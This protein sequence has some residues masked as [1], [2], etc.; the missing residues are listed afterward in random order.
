MCGD[1]MVET[2]ED[3]GAI[4]T[5]QMFSTTVFDG[6][7]VNG[8]NIVAN[9]YPEQ[10]KRILLMAHWDTRPFADQGDE[11][12]HHTPILGANDAASGVAVLME[13]ARVLARN[14]STAV[15]VDLL[16]FDVE[17][18]GAPSFAAND[19]SG[20]PTSYCLGSQYW[21]EN[22]HDPNYQA[23]YG[24]LLDM[25]GAEGARFYWEGYSKR[26]ASKVLNTV[27]GEAE[28]A[29]FGEYFVRKQIEG[30]IDDHLF[31]NQAGGIPT[32]DIIHH[33]AINGDPF[34]AHWHK[35]TDD[36]SHISKETLKAVGQ[37]LVQVIYTEPSFD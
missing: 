14:D 20:K 36:M 18:Y 11:Q 12:D 4:V 33:D 17:D 29:G 23:Y 8:R 5:E 25:V 31:V 21:G 26:Y 10:R 15:G 22:K 32:I 2:L 7:S 6:S 1:F 24:I 27:W 9:F 30:L 16:F 35:T 37:T 19:L 3:Y 13:I 28:K 34:F